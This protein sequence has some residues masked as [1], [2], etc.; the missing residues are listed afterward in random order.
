MFRLFRFISSGAVLA[1]G[2]LALHPAPAVEGLPVATAAAV[3]ASTS[4][5]WGWVDFCQRYEGEC[6]L[7]AA[8]EK[9][10]TLSPHALAD[11]K[12]VNRWV[13]AHVEPTTDMDHWGV[14][15]R[16]D[17]PL[18]GKGDCEDFALFKRKMLMQAGYPRA[19]LLVTV[20]HDGAEAGHAILTV[21]TDK[22]D[23]VLDNLNDEVKPWTT[24]GYQFVK[25][26][27]QEDPNVWVK[28]Q[29]PAQAKLASSAP[30]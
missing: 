13:N 16:W 7:G 17:L 11:I 30:M 9:E 12:R 10:V 24:A 2:W 29:S 18:D 4:V 22:G 19:A 20:V 15:D 26:Q 28:I 8:G 3:G 14:E 5:P 6:A 25:R 21:K 27:S 1:C 23:L